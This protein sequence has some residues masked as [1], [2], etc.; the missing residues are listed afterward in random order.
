[1]ALHYIY[2]T[3]YDRLVWDVGHQA[4]PHK[5][6]TG[7]RELLHTIKQDKGLAPFPTPQRER[8]RHLRR[9]SFEH[10]HLG[11]ARHG[12]RGRQ[13]RRGSPRGG[14]HRRRRAHRRHGLRGAE[15]CGLRAGGSAHHPERQRHVDLR[16]RRR[17][18]KLPG[19]RAVRTHVCA[20]ARGRQEGAAADA[21]RVGAGTP[22]GGAPEGHGASRHAVRGD[23]IQLHR[24]GRRPRPQGAGQRPSAT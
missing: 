5:V 20:S 14:H 16:E 6:L 22:L 18:V 8:I 24:A 21:D 4:Y 17:A 19:A 2:N 3:P 10:L 12:G 23:G 15:P 1:M 7:R 11:R 9:R 13:A